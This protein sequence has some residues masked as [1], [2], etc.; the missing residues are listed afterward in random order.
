MPGFE[1]CPAASAPADL[2]LAALDRHAIQLRC[3]PLCVLREGELHEA[4]ALMNWASLLAHEEAL[5]DG[6][7]LAGRRLHVLFVRIE[8]D[9]PNEHRA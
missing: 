3:G 9:A 5:L 4:E 1:P 6:A 2:Q 8:A 7:D